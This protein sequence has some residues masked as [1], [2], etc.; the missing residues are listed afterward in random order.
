M[1]TIT[2]RMSSRESLMAAFVE[3]VTAGEPARATVFVE[4]L[5]PPSTRPADPP[6]A[7]PRAKTSTTAGHL[8]QGLVSWNRGSST[9]VPRLVIQHLAS[10]VLWKYR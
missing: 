5:E 9:P 8:A 3:T 1:S 6:D 2:R 4:D 10:R 7:A